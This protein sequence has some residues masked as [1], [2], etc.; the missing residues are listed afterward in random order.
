MPGTEQSIAELSAPPV[1]DPISRRVWAVALVVAFGILGTTV[2][3]SPAQAEEAISLVDALD[4]IESESGALCGT[5]TSGLSLRDRIDALLD[6]VDDS[7]A[8]IRSSDFPVDRLNELIY[9]RLAIRASRDVHD[10]CN[11][12]PSAVLERKQGYCVGIAAIYLALA[13]RLD[14]P[15]HAVAIPSHVYLRYDDGK[16]RIDIETLAMGAPAPE[17]LTALKPPPS[18]EM[19]GPVTFPRDLTTDGFL[20]QVRNNLGVIHSVRGDHAAAAAE[21]RKA[22]DLDPLLSAAW[23]NWGNDLLLAGR[24]REAIEKLDEALRLYP[25]DT[26][27]LNNRGRAWVALGK[28]SRARKD[29]E[30]ALVIDPQ[31]RPA[32]RNLKAFDE[33]RAPDGETAH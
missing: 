31:F 16:S 5:S 18:P 25:M 33:K 20:A 15:I 22:L 27:A 1:P 19:R 3:S 11:L 28:K 32:R 8:G 10:P 29:F 24:Q 23:Y 7:S 2:T 17:G 6:S 12:L 21:Y 30:A 26:W 13:E 14:L 9:R 4:R